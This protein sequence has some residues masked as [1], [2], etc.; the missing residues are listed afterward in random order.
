MVEAS[1]NYRCDGASLKR[2]GSGGRSSWATSLRSG[3]PWTDPQT[4][5]AGKKHARSQTLSEPR[6]RSALPARLKRVEN[7]LVFWGVDRNELGTVI[8]SMIRLAGR[9]LR[10]SGGCTRQERCWD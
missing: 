3:Q 10:L 7:L 6:W 1:G 2:P 8:I 4:P 9:D 5:G